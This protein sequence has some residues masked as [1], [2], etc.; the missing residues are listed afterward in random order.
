MLSSLRF[1]VIGLLFYSATVAAS[2]PTTVPIMALDVTQLATINQLLDRIAERR[3]IFI[4]EH[5]DRYED[6]L[7]QLAIIAG[8]HQRGKSIV[9]GMEFFQQPFQAAL[10]AFIAG[11]IDELELLR[12]TEYFDRWRYDYRMY[13][14]IL[15][16]ARQYRIPLIALNIA[17]EFTAK[18]GA[19]GLQSLT[20]AERAQI[21]AEFER[22]DPA[23]RQRLETIF[24][25]HPN[26]QQHEFEHFLE[27]QLLWDEGMAA[28]TA[29]ALT[30]F[31]DRTVIVLAGAGHLEYGQGIP[32]RVTRRQPVSTAIL[33]N[34]NG[35]RPDPT[36]AD[37]LLYPQPLELTGAGVLGVQ[38]DPSTSGGMLVKAFAE[39]S[40]AQVAGMALGDRIIR[41]GAMPIVSYADI[42]I[43]LLD[44]APGQRVAVEIERQRL[45]GTPERL[46]LQVELR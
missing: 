32:K 29:Q 10:D 18:V 46:I 5:H 23:Y 13:R 44:Q 14:P 35:R 11:E 2:A 16:F 12:R 20:D 8:L 30:D 27:A 33:L 45:L 40:G 42:R 9:I 36:V 26:T 41:V 25:Q 19:G 34:G 17:S 7:T 31:P 38:L 6:H 1:I 43:A 21:P 39:T 22:H 24:K 4:G 28:R 15:Q 3:V 37:F